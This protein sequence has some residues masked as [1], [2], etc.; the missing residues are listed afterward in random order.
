[1]ILTVLLY[2]LSKHI[3]KCDLGRPQTLDLERIDH[4]IDPLH[5]MESKF[6]KDGL[7]H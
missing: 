3:C 7:T 1:M 5:I 2:Q 4:P 6:Q